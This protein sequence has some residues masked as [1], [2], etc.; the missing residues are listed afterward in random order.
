MSDL[1]AIAYDDVD[2]S[3]DV[4]QT[5]ER[6]GKEHVVE[7]EDAVIVERR[8]DG[9]IKL[10]QS[11][12]MVSMGAASGVLWGGLIGLIFMV[13]L[14]GAAIGGA[15]GAA[16]GAMTDYGIDDSFMRELGERLQPGTAAIFLL[17]SK[18]TPD[19]LFPE[20][21]RY[22]GHVLQTSLS[23]EAEQHLREAADAAGAE[24][25]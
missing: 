23:N 17:A 6:L 11:R 21:A 4:M 13:P 7:L 2:T 24:R 8:D 15:A 10:H 1:I 14:L 18:S 12:P 22:G 9:K 5:L 25:G 19:K 3:R 20:V 16:G